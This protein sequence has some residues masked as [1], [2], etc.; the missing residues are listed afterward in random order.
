MQFQHVGGFP[1]SDTG[2]SENRDIRRYKK[3]L[4]K[5]GIEISS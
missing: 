5:I 2:D 1:L 4:Q 3:D